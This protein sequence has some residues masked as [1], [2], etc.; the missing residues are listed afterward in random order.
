MGYFNFLKKLATVPDQP[1]NVAQFYQ[2]HKQELRRLVATE[3]SE[4]PSIKDFRYEFTSL[5]GHRY[6]TIPEKMQIPFQRFAN[7]LNFMEWFQNGL[8]PAEWDRIRAELT[9]CFAHM[10]AKT[11]QE[12]DMAIKAG[13]LFAE[14][15]R[16]RVY[17]TPLYVMINL[18]ANYLIRED[19]DPTVVSSTIHEQ[20]CD[21]IQA[22][23]EAGR[24]G[25]FLTIPQLKVLN[26]VLSMSPE[27]LT[28]L[29]SQLHKEGVRDTEAL[30]L[31]L[32]WT[33]AEK[34]KK[35]STKV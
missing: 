11:P 16:R 19:E 29:L 9:V 14:M 30:K 13:L 35:T 8:A 2:Q 27:E 3:K 25:F 33:G 12:K 6:Y 18:C 10:V 21:D 24:N 17:A 15:D 34:D 23:V 28:E 20:K 1:V 26:S 4:Y 5:S 31:Y 7:G 32:S 22:E